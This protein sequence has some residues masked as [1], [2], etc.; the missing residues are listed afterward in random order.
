[1]SENTMNLALF[2]LPV[3]LFPG[4]VTRLRIFEQ[5]YLRMIKEAA[6]DKGFALTT[7]YPD[8]LHNVGDRASWVKIIDFQTLEDGMLGVDIQA[9]SV[10]AIDQVT[11]EEDGLI[12]GQ[13]TQIPH[14][15]PSPSLPQQQ[16]QTQQ[17]QALAAKLKQVLEAN[18]VLKAFYPQPCYDDA[19]WV[20]LRWLEILPISTI[21]KS[22]FFA[23]DSFD[24]AVGLLRG[25]VLAG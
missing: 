16:P 18:P 15:P 5:R 11:V 17:I 19:N 4:G 14:W 1:M 22:R 10:L 13:T 2:P 24:M 25:M 9:Q 20:C 23:P 12:R 6:G 3:I 7:F 8:K 21:D